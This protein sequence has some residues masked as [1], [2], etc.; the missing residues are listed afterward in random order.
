VGVISAY[1]GKIIIALLLKFAGNIFK[2]EEMMA[3]LRRPSQYC[4]Y[5]GSLYVFE[6]WVLRKIL[7]L[8]RN[9]FMAD[10]RRLYNEELMTC[11]A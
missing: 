10:W 2:A 11:T 8:R 6:N 3:A 1:C 4:G 9:S 5:I 7:G